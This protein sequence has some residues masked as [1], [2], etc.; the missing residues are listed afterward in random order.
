MK[1]ITD[2]AELGKLNYWIIDLL[3]HWI[4]RLGPMSYWIRLTKF[5]PIRDN[6]HTDK[7]FDTFDANFAIF[8]VGHDAKHF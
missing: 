2:L 3:N 5:R 4:I 1:T 6:Q 7:E 8:V